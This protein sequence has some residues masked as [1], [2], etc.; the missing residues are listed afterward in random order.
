[1]DENVKTCASCRYY[2]YTLSWP[3]MDIN[4]D[5]PICSY[6]CCWERDLGE[7]VNKNIVYVGKQAY[8]TCDRHRYR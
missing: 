4:P 3:D 1:M 7:V 6:Q 8:M 5:G 2:S